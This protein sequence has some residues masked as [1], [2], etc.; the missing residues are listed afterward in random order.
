MVKTSMNGDGEGFDLCDIL[1]GLQLDSP[2]S[3]RCVAA[4]CD[5]LKN[6]RGVGIH[7]ASIWLEMGMS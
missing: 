1:K 5:Y 6:C 3:N 4:G 2:S 7:R